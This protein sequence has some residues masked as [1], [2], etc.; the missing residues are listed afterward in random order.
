MTD[1]SV[2]YVNC[3]ALSSDN[4]GMDRLKLLIN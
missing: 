3:P 4:L 2:I 1:R